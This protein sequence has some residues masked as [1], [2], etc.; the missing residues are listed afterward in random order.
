M[1]QRLRS[2][3]TYSNVMASAAVFIALGGASYAAIKLPRNSVGS[4]QLKKNA[5]T[6]KKVKDKSLT[7]AD[8]KAG[9]LPRGAAGAKGDTG[10]QGPQ[11]E[12]G[13][14][15]AGGTNGANG[16]DGADG[17]DGQDFQYAH[18]VVV[19]ATGSGTENGDA[20]LAAMDGITDNSSS[21]RYLLKLEPGFY[22]LGANSLGIKSFVDVEGSGVKTTRIHRSSGAA[23]A[24]HLSTGEVRDVTIESIPSTGSAV[25]ADGSAGPT[26]HDV[27]LQATATGPDDAT[28][29]SL[30]SSLGFMQ[31]SQA[32]AQTGSGTAV[33][34]SVDGA[35][36]SIA[37]RD[38]VA[39]ASGG[40][41]STAISSAGGAS[42]FVRWSTLLGTNNA[43]GTAAI[44]TGGGSVYVIG[45]ELLPNGSAP[46]KFGV[47]AT[48]G[49]PSVRIG[50]SMVGGSPAV[51]GVAPTC[52]GD[53]TTLFAAL[54][55]SCT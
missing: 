5:V 12:K 17:R 3:L 43:S 36:T 49:A 51:S 23:A 28:A 55:T 26:L 22:D 32:L 42:V 6:G 44:S 7:A 48:G 13:Q 10:A 8:F 41:V 34:V 46:N 11:G 39:S 4:A 21:A 35:A 40:T 50:S 19:K 15:G 29:L 20:L 16:L 38:S 52:V 33:A 37:M 18:V 25:A 47:L 27:A 31:D 45:S 24:V 53:Y 30:T 14:P 1:R 2:S 54:N 9:A